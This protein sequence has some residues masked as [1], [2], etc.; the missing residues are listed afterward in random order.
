MDVP[1]GPLIPLCFSGTKLSFQSRVPTRD[2]LD[3]CVHIHMTSSS[4]WKP[5]S[6]TLGK[7]AA[8]SYQTEDK[9][10]HAFPHND[11]IPLNPVWYLFE[12]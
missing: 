5:G 12:K 9:I 2:E 10:P 7:V 1:D 3:S 8:T 11:L 4:E 6:V